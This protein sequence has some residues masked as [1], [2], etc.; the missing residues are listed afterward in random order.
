MSQSKV[1]RRVSRNHARYRG[2]H[3]I[4]IVPMIDM[5]IILV[6][7]LLF[8]AVFTKTNILEL[9]LPGARQCRAR[10]AAGAES[11]SDRP[12]RPDRSRRSRHRL[13]ADR[14][15]A[16]GQRTISRACR[17]TCAGEDQVQRQDGRDHPAGAGHRVRHA[18]QAMDTV[19]VFPTSRARSGTSRSCSRMSRWE[20][21]RHDAYRIKRRP[22]ARATRSR[23]GNH[24][25]LVPFIDMLTMLVVF[26]LVHTSDVDVLPNTKNIS[27]PQSIA[28][29]KPHPSVVV[30]ITKDELLV[31]GRSIATLAQL[32]ASPDA[33]I[34]PLQLALQSQADKVLAGAAKEDIEDREIT[35][36]GDKQHAVRGAAQS[37]GDRHR[38]RLRQGV[39]RRHRARVRRRGPGPSRGAYGVADQ[40]SRRNRM[41]LAP[42]YRLFDLPWS[43]T[44]EAEQ[45]FR[46]VLR[47]ALHRLRLLGDPD[48][49]AAGARA[50][51]DEGAGDPGPHRQADARRKRRRRRHRRRR[52]RR[53]SRSRRRRS[54]SRS[55]RRRSPTRASVRRTPAC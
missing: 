40:L 30:M 3:D 17:T 6:F 48:P 16:A 51:N 24:M 11:R 33:V 14:C 55:R 37:H 27:I 47:I 15:P 45:R 12:R 8:T 36:M 13:A 38:C 32:E 41:T 44:E 10:P 23:A 54:S 1:A 34:A 53:R 25:T 20:T 21:R 50:R 43:P 35:I 49:V 5:M 52:S 39:A 28:D 26:L 22:Q 29:M 7:F 42:Y 4:N 2:R 19:R 31:N 9:N 46:K 18:R